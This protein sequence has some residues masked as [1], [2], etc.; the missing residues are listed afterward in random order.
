MEE[1]GLSEWHIRQK[2]REGKLRAYQPN[3]GKPPVRIRRSDLRKLL[4]TDT[5]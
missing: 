5:E 3:P 4:E 2:I 1:T